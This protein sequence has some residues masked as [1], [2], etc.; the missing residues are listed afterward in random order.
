MDPRTADFECE[1][2]YLG[3]ERNKGLF[4]LCFQIK[5]CLDDSAADDA[6]PY[7]HIT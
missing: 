5:H 6:V 2:F 3:T 1:N 4:P 7:C